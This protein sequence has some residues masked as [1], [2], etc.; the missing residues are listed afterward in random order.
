MSDEENIF[1]ETIS[2]QSF[3]RNSRTHLDRLDP[4]PNGD[5]GATKFMVFLKKRE[6]VDV[7]T[8]RAFLAKQ[9]APRLA[10]NPNVLKLRLHLLEEYQNVDVVL[11][12]KSGHVSHYKPPE[13][14]YQ[15]VYEMAFRDPLGMASLHDS[16][17]WKDM[18]PEQRRHIREAHAGLVTKTYTWLYHGEMTLAALRTAAVADQIRRIGAIN[19]LRPDVTNLMLG[20]S[21]QGNIS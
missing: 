18:V 13:M 19:Q 15:A 6:G 5:H 7:T 9:L 4:T 16:S 14:Q 17:D 10:E 20:R 2:Y 12:S 11:D 21:A 3:G 8:F 1:E